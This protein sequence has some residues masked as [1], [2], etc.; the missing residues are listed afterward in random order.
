VRANSAS[1]S[2]IPPGGSVLKRKT[3]IWLGVLV[4]V[5]GGIGFQAKKAHDEKLVTEVDIRRIERKDLRSV[6][7]ASG[8][9]KPKTMVD[10]SAAVSGKVLE[11]CVKEGD[12][13]VKGQRLLRI[14]PKPFETQVSQLDASIESARANVEL[15]RANLRQS[16]SNLKRTEGLAAQG[17]VTAEQLESERTNVDVERARLKATEQEL[18]RLQASLDQA[19]HELTKVDVLSDIAGTV[20]AVNIEAGE[21]AFVGAFNNPATVLL[22]V[23]DLEVIEA[24]VEVDESMAVEAR[25]AQEAELEIDAHRDWVFHGVVTEVG[26]TP[27][28]RQT[29]GEREGTSYLVKILVKDRIPEVRPGLTC[30][31]RI[32][33][34]ARTSV[35]CVPI[36][37]MALRKPASE[38]LWRRDTGGGGP[39]QA[40]AAEPPAATSPPQGEAAPA[41]A[42]PDRLAGSNATR[43]KDDEGKVEGV[44]YVKEGKAWFQPVKRGITGEKD[45]ELV[46]SG[47]LEEG[48]EIV[49][50][51]YKALHTL[52]SGDPIRP[53]QPKDGET[54]KG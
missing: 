28:T 13:V 17:L 44:F 34:D 29:G 33:T 22:T 12:Q 47:G 19:A 4:V 53:A 41:D 23:A 21:Y 3:V 11:V 24:E 10:V 42:A 8:K 46:D 40:M 36:Q 15:Q 38:S 39:S 43:R 26:H 49:V 37:A 18:P 31:A 50:G 32:C 20:T 27:V 45:F 25:P 6:I 51:P 9:I 7:A 54:Q 1:A 16:E 48:A 2:A 5:A 14:D 52:K 30:S 35:L